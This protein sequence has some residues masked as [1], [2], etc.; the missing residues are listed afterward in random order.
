MT[1]GAA[2][3]AGFQDHAVV[4]LHDGPSLLR[5]LPEAGGRLLSWSLD[6]I[7][8]I[9]WPE[10][11]DWSRPAKIRGGNPLLF[12]F[13]ARHFFGGQSGRWQ[14]ATGAVHELP[15]HGFAREGSFRVVDAG[16]THATLELETRHPG[17][18]FDFQFRVSYRL[19]QGTLEAGFETTN[20]GTTP[21]PYYAG[22]HFYFAL[23]AH[24]RGSW[25][26]KLP[27]LRQARQRDDGS[28]EDLT[29]DAGEVRLDHPGLIDTFHLLEGAQSLRIDHSDGRSLVFDLPSQTA[30]WHAVTTWTENPASPFYCIEPWLGLPNAIHH[31][32]G[33]R[34]IAPGQ[35]ETAL[36]RLSAT[37]WTKGSPLT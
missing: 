3:R 7:P 35:K 33:L 37:G 27:S 20:L 24:E 23:P 21:L 32:R 2:P 25:T 28:I 5:I 18:P 17:Y 22:H 9:H 8:V 19:G 36:C 4:E 16:P 31:R 11:P 30:P 13:I 26:L 29:A 12:P 1:T 6:G 15:M 14:D 10:Q 34:W